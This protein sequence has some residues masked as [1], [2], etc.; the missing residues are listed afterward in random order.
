MTGGA[1]RD[2]E[3]S[4]GRRYEIAFKNRFFINIQDMSQPYG[5][6]KTFESKHDNPMQSWVIFINIFKN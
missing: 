6:K 5:E 3:L 4:Q 2:K 1:E